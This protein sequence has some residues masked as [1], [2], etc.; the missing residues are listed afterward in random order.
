MILKPG[1]ILKK[2]VKKTPKEAPERQKIPK[3]PEGTVEVNQAEIWQ[4]E[5]NVK[6]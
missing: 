3:D 1:P 6:C 4:R 5:Q 2:M